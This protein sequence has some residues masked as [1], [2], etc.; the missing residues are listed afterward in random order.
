MKF[1]D[2]S[3]DKVG[4]IT[5][6]LSGTFYLVDHQNNRCTPRYVCV[7]G[8]VIYERLKRLWRSDRAAFTKAVREEI[9]QD[10]RS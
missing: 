10:Y 5:D 6:S 8:M 3:N 7:E 9:Y 4:V 2:L 1:E